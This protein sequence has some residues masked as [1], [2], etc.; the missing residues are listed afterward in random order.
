MIQKRLIIYTYVASCPNF[1]SVQIAAATAYKRWI[2]DIDINQYVFPIYFCL[3][4][5]RRQKCFVSYQLAP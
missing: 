1:T 2:L 5:K 4:E 3:T